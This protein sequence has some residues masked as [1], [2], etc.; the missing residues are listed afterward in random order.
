LASPWKIFGSEELPLTDQAFEIYLISTV[1]L[2]EVRGILEMQL[3]KCNALIA[4]VHGGT[5]AGR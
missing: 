3:A 2:G 4:I 1:D 5:R